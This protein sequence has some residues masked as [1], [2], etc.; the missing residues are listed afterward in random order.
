[1]DRDRIGRGGHG[2][3]GRHARVAIGGVDSDL[4]QF[5]GRKRAI[6]LGDHAGRRPGMADAH[7]GLERVS[8]GFE[9]R[10]LARREVDRHPPILIGADRSNGGL[11]RSGLFRPAAKTSPGG[12]ASPAKKPEILFPSCRGHGRDVAATVDIGKAGGQP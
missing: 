12:V 7:D 8:A 5:V 9:V 4:D 2:L 11:H 1:M 10:A 3:P 6:D